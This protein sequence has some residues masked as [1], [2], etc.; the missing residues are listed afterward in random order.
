VLILRGQRAT[1]SS[2]GLL[3][4]LL[5]LTAIFTSELIVASV[6]LDGAVLLS[7]GGLM[8][9]VGA[10]GPWILRC[11]VGFAAIFV[12]FAYLKNK[13]ALDRISAQVAQIPI[14]RAALAAH[15][16]SILIFGGLSSVLYAGNQSGFPGTPSP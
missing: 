7:K 4:R 2:L 5:I 11:L 9:L 8:S 3:H 16:I 1:D 6:L 10:W 14:R 12:T 15:F 13:P